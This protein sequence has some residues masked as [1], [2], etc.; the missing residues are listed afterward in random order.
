MLDI[1]NYNRDQLKFIV[2]LSDKCGRYEGNS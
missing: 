1:D 2:Q